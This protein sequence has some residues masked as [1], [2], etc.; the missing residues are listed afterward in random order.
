MQ[1]R[2][3]TN[4]QLRFQRIL[5]LPKMKNVFLISRMNYKAMS[6]QIFVNTLKPGSMTMKVTNQLQ[7]TVTVF[8]P[9]FLAAQA[10]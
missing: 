1:P 7:T 6:L 3:Y 4:N 10:L 8:V 2:Q 5:A 9:L